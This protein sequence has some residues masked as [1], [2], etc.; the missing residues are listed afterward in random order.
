MRVWATSVS[1]SRPDVSCVG[2]IGSYARGDWGVG[3]DLDVVMIVETAA[4]PFEQ[5][6]L[7]FDLS[8]IPVPVDLLIYTRAEWQ[9]LAEGKEKFWRTVDR[10]AV[11]VYQR[12][13]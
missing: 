11:W 3:S 10:E 8:T 7:K 2:Y 13:K 6:S 5:R 9:N 12:Q 4:D 1:A